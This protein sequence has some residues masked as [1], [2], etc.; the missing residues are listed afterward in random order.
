M[1]RSPVSSIFVFVFLGTAILSGRPAAGTEATSAS[2]Q[3]QGWRLIDKHER[4]EKHP[5]IAPYENLTRIL[6]IT[7]LVLEKDGKRQTCRMIYDSQRD[8]ISE[9][10][11]AKGSP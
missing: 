9:T 8:N 1:P 7:T 10:C 4:Q 11:T 3:E 6:Q 5:G 2:L